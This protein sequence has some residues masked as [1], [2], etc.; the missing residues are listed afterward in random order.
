MKQVLKESFETS[1]KRIQFPVPVGGWKLNEYK[2]IVGN[3]LLVEEQDF[4]LMFFVL[5]E[6]E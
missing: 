1:G 2:K 4:S 3:K 6:Q 5:M